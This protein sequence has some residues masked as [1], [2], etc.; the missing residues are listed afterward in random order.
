MLG[1]IIIFLSLCFVICLVTIS[2]E[3]YPKEL[4]GTVQTDFLGE[5]SLLGQTSASGSCTDP[6]RQVDFCFLPL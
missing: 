4:H 1:I 5:K 3:K 6:N 2:Q